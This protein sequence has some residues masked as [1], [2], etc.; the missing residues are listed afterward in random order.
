MRGCFRIADLLPERASV[1]HS[2]QLRPAWQIVVYRHRC[3]A[4][5][6]EMLRIST[7][8]PARAF[9]F[10]INASL[11]WNRNKTDGGSVAAIPMH[12]LAKAAWRKKFTF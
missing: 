2:I 12:F 8:H 4:L 10:K 1:A 3:S 6:L 9:Q 5:P 11:I 7:R